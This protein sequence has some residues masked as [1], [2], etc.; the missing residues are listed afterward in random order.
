M[1]SLL[2]STPDLGSVQLLESMAGNHNRCFVPVT[3]RA[4]AKADHGA[5][6]ISDCVSALHQSLLESAQIR[7]YQPL[8]DG[9]DF[10]D[11]QAFPQQLNRL[12]DALSAVEPWL[13]HD[14][15]LSRFLPL[16]VPVMG[17]ANLIYL[18]SHPLECA[19]RLQQR[20]RFPLAFG[21]ALWESYVLSAL[22]SLKGLP[23]FI[24][25][26]SEI[27]AAPRP[28]A[29]RL[30]QVLG[31]E[32]VDPHA[33]LIDIDRLIDELPDQSPAALSERIRPAQQTLFDAL[34]RG[35]TAA[36]EDQALSDESR[37]IL[38]HYGRLRAG[39]EQ[40]RADRDNYRDLYRTRPMEQT[41]SAAALTKPDTKDVPANEA[42]ST[43]RVHIKG[44][45]VIEFVAAENSP[46]L[47]LLRNCL[48]H[49]SRLPDEMVYLNY[50]ESGSDGLYFMASSL[51][52]LEISCLNDR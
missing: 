20:W 19:L 23:C 5:F 44:R 24:L 35:S 12:K 22:Q 33:E 10:G 14:I 43:V 8:P 21:L 51:V 38:E 3:S 30:G 18:Y 9:F 42:L 26:T 48:A 6:V 50:G 27:R 13:I 49:D 2:L 11:G 39:F 1:N 36:L 46:V 37:D 7:W 16:W 31:L 52:T 4:P 32:D 47:D 15:R 45:D 29:R 25:S 17:A 41:N 40:T 28:S 34:Q